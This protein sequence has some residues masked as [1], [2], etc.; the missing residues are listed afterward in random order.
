MFC[1]P[2]YSLVLFDETLLTLQPPWADFKSD[3]SVFKCMTFL[4]CVFIYLCAKQHHIYLEFINNQ[5]VNAKFLK[6]P[7]CMKKVLTV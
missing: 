2:V 7:A 5:P 1:V 6:S 3:S 4:M